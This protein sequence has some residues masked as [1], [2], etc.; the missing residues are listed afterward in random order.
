ML[1][2]V[3]YIHSSHGKVILIDTYKSK[4]YIVSLVGLIDDIDNDRLKIVNLPKDS[5]SKTGYKE[6]LNVGNYLQE[7]LSHTVLQP[8]KIIILGASGHKYLVNSTNFKIKMFSEET[9][10]LMLENISSVN[11]I[12]Y[13]LSNAMVDSDHSE[14]ILKDD[15]IIPTIDQALSKPS[16]SETLDIDEKY[17]DRIKSVETLDM[18]LRMIGKEASGLIVTKAGL[19]AQ[20]EYMPEYTYSIKTNSLGE[21][22][23]I[24]YINIKTSPLADA[25]YIPLSYMLELDDTDE[26]YIDV[27]LT[28]NSVKSLRVVCDISDPTLTMLRYSPNA[29][30]R[31]RG[32]KTELKSIYRFAANLI[33]VKCIDLTELDTSSVTD[34]TEAFINCENI[35]EVKFSN[36]PIIRKARS[37]FQGDLDLK[38]IRGLKISRSK[39]NSTVFSKCFKL[40]DLIKE[41][42]V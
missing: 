28:N 33:G 15:V 29:T 30:I 3:G 23:K 5:N 8:R 12:S 19:I 42:F 2:I 27:E 14:I 40:Q 38:H 41:K 36:T 7:E 10:I 34:I 21:R 26:T 13:L 6:D 35:Q 9:L 18:K 25:V 24:G 16:S 11:S 32:A 39:E 22:T 17:R 37:A 31:I 20:C 1:Y 4:H